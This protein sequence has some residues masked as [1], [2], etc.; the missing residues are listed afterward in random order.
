MT[1]DPA[2]ELYVPRRARSD[3]PVAAEIDHTKTAVDETKCG[4]VVGRPP[5]IVREATPP[6]QPVTIVACHPRRCEARLR[7]RAIALAGEACARALRVAV[8]RNPLFV[9]RFVD[10]ALSALGAGSAVKVRLHPSDAR[11]CAHAV[12]ADIVGD[13]AL[14]RGE[15]RIESPHGT[16]GAT[17]AERAVVLVRATADA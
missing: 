16:L 6:P 10:D 12:A 1:A 11:A 13:P 8:A 5:E 3:E 7:D 9:A 2:F 15:V 4:E 17:I 14:E